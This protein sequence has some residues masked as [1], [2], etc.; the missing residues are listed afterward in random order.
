MGRSDPYRH[1]PLIP[2]RMVNP[3][4]S[5]F[6]SMLKTVLWTSLAF[7]VPIV[8]LREMGAFESLEL[9]TYDRFVQ[10][11]SSDKL[12]DRITLVTIGDSDIEQLQQFPIHDSTFAQALAKLESY[13]PRVIGLDISRDVPQGPPAGRVRLKQVIEQSQ[14]I[15]SGCLLSSKTYGGSPPAPGTPPEGVAFADFPIDPDKT[16]R[17][18]QLVSIPMQPDQPP[19]IQHPCN[20]AS[21]ENELPSL[22][23]QAAL[24]YLNGSQI[25]PEPSDTGEIRL[26]QQVL[27]RID[28]RFGGYARADTPDYQMMLNYRGAGPLF[29][30]IPFTDLLQGKANPE[31]VRDRVVLIG[32]TSRVSKDEFPTPYFDTQND[33]RM[34]HGVVVH[35]HAVSQILSAVLDQH[36][37]I[38]SWPEWAELLWIWAW[39]LG[40]GVVAFY[41]RRLGWF[42]LLGI[43]SGGVLIGAGYGLFITQGLWIPVAP[44]L[45]LAGITALAVRSLETAQQS[46]YAQAVYE[47]LR[48]QLQGNRGE[49]DR[50]GDYLARLVQRAQAVRQGRDAAELLSQGAAPTELATPE[51]RALYDQIAAQVRADLAAQQAALQQNTN[52]ARSRSNPIGRMQALVKRAQQSRQP[53][54]TPPTP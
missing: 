17:R 8:G 12:D 19:R 32:S 31:W 50:T 37:L 27:R 38:Q 20:D 43:A 40:S 21:P 44:P 15:V 35:A 45:M 4:H 41:C 23:F 33:S 14:T 49:R 51:M 36:P 18:V 2:R 11:R 29:R 30:E 46:G 16:V 52:Q 13:Q 22:S 54:P 47:H 5:R 39:S 6:S 7:T 42:L 3:R 53:P 28:T 24:M 34:M 48:E 25:Q 1:S 26:R 9:A 10:Q